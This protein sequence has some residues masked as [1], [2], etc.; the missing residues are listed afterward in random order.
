MVSP[1]FIALIALSIGSFIAVFEGAFAPRLKLPPCWGASPD[2]NDTNQRPVGTVLYLDHADAE[3]V[4]RTESREQ[5]RYVDNVVEFR[6]RPPRAS[7]CECRNAAR[8]A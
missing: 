8:A 7:G 2:P 4:D 1:Y 6:P 5:P 3:H